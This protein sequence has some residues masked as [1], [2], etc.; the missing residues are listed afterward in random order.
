MNNR[1]RITCLVLGLL[2]VMSLLPACRPAS[3]QTPAPTLPTGA[4]YAP[5]P[6]A[7]NYPGVD[8]SGKGVVTVD[9]LRREGIPLVKKI[10]QFTPSHATVSLVGRMEDLQALRPHNMRIDFFWG[11][12]GGMGNSMVQGTREALS[13]NFLAVNTLARRLLKYEVLPYWVYAFNPAPLQPEGG[14]FRSPPVDLD[15]WAEIC[16]RTAANFRS[17]G[18]RVAF[19]EIWNEPDFRQE[20]FTGTWDQYLDLYRHGAKG[21]REGDPDAMV[22]GLSLAYLDQAA[23]RGELDRFLDMVLAES[24]PLDFISFHNYGLAGA[25]RHILA[26][27]EALQGDSRFR[28]VQMHYNEFNTMTWPWENKRTSFMVAADIW[29]AIELFLGHTDLTLVH[30]ALFRDTRE[31]LALVDAA[32]KKTAAY[33]ALEIFARMPFDRVRT[34]TGTGDL[35]A[36]ASAEPG[37]A[38]LVLYNTG[39]RKVA[40]KALLDRIP[41]LAGRL[42]V[43]RIDSRY[44]SRQDDPNNPDCS[45]ERTE[46]R[47]F[48]DSRG[49]LWEG[50]VPARGVVFL[51]AVHPDAPSLLAD[52]PAVG[53]VVRRDYAYPNRGT[54]CFADA[55]EPTRTAWTGMGSQSAAS[56]LVALT[57]DDCPDAFRLEI[58]P[59]GTPRDEKADPDAAAGVRIDFMDAAGSPVHSVFLHDGRDADIVLP[60]GTG[61]TA[62]TSIGIVPGEDR[63][64]LV[65][66]AAM[67]PAGWNRRIVVTFLIQNGT[68]G[69]VIRYRL[70][71][72]EDQET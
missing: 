1:V 10:A 61:R 46:S 37:R 54:D 20:F 25:D 49:L 24:L 26:A 72:L 70:L 57:L 18:I 44:S 43:Y 29:S 19:H 22:G 8:R 4:P 53:T 33:N 51:E 12:S 59:Y 68:P 9:F 41:F 5:D 32:G 21:I 45:L 50:D 27:R 34:E 2:A 55:D 23:A 7:E 58:D 69:E 15:A 36:I 14:D 66:L 35:H 28:T 60:W 48:Q 47:T 3:T 63:C 64:V 13:Y 17:E 38:C 62:D 6:D 65:D 52:R 42:D 40:A 31:G 11:L 39:S 71:P 30:W 16:R 67:A 56:A